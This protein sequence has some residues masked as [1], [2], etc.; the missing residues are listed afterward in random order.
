MSSNTFLVMYLKIK[1]NNNNKKK[2]VDLLSLGN[3]SYTLQ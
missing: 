3:N 1:I 2:I